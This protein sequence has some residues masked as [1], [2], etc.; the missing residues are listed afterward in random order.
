MHIVLMDELRESG[1]WNLQDDNDTLESKGFKMTQITMEN[2]NISGS[3][4]VQRDEL[5]L[6]L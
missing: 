1:I 5:T 6:A 2:C 3:G 4:E